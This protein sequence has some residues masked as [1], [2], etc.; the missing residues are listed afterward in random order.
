[1]DDL[2]SFDGS[3]AFPIETGV[4]V[5]T[6]RSSNERVKWDTDKFPFA[7]M[8]VGDSFVVHAPES[9]PLIYTQNA[10]SGAASSWAKKRHDAYPGVPKPVFT[11]RQQAGHRI[12]CW[13]TA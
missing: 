13:R 7:R 12:R 1:M 5:S 11:T 9:E 10:V 8:S 4:P 6:D 2:F 3:A